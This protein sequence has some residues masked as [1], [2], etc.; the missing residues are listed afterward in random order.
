MTPNR[1]TRR[2]LL[3]GVFALLFGCLIGK[4]ASTRVPDQLEPISATPLL[5]S[6]YSLPEIS[7]TITNI[8][9]F[10]RQALSVQGNTGPNHHVYLF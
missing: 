3:G 6:T 8:L 5:Y 10:R 9:R 4:K 1:P 2:T 7:G